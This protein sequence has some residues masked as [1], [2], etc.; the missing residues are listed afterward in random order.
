MSLFYPPYL[1][2]KLPAQYGDALSI[3]FELNRA[4]GPLDLKD[5]VVRA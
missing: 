1:E 4:Q 2:G 5:I 3:P